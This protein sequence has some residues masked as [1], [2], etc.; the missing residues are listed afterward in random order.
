MRFGCLGRKSI[1]AVLAG[2]AAAMA[3]AGQPALNVEAHVVSGD[4]RIFLRAPGPLEYS[5]SHPRQDLYIVDL[6]GAGAQGPPL[7]QLL[8]SGV[9]S[10]YRLTAGKADRRGARL[11]VLLSKPASLRVERPSRRLLVLIFSATDAGP[12]ADSGQ[13]S[14]GNPEP[15]AGKTP[16]RPPL[17]GS[18][19]TEAPIAAGPAPATA[20][21]T[22]SASPFHGEPISV[23]FKDVD[24]KDF[25]RLIHVVS[26]LNVVVDSDVK[27]TLTMVLDQVPWD[28]ALDIVLRDNGLSSERQGNVLRIATRAT[29]QREAEQER[30]LAKA[31]EQAANVVTVTRTLSYANA[32]KLRQTLKQFLSP[33]GEILADARSNTLIIRDIPSV[34]PTID[35]LIL[36]LDRK[37]PQ[38]EIQARVVEATRAFA[39]ELGTQFGFAV[40]GGTGSTQNVIGGSPG[41]GTSPIIRDILPPPPL[42]SGG[43][44]VLIPGITG[45]AIPLNANLGASAPTSGILFG[46]TEPNL[47]LDLII[48]AAESK[49]I[50]R[51]LSQPKLITQDNEEATVKQGTKIPVQTVVN[52]TISVQF[53]DAV[54]ELEVTPQ[55]TADGTV[56]M[57]IHVENTAIDQGIPRIL[58]IPALDTQSED[59]KVLVSDGGTVVIGGI[60]LSQQQNNVSQV[61]LFGSIPVIGNLFKHTEVSTQT[62]ELLFFLTPRV[63]PG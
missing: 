40:A 4:T 15:H 32:S 44:S 10:S 17:S 27:G 16:A 36:R 26:G 37:S 52:N 58:G 6:K 59:T 8:P 18:I 49:G 29:L 43:S 30:D 39:R 33:R 56:F 63:L 24:L 5:T 12:R 45:S 50:G 20:A 38:V 60:I 21:Q 1:L 7:A 22:G 13:T 11:E 3:M 28:Q 48:S 51:M 53:I 19:A 34:L 23:N 54:L 42:V 61:P 62:Q 55:I 2:G 57:K 47:A 31:Q 41:V 35:R 14:P 25:F 9:V 46:H